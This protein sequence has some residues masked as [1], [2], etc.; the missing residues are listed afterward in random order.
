MYWPASGFWLSK[1]HGHSP[2]L[3]VHCLLPAKTLLSKQTTDSKQKPEKT[4]KSTCAH[5][6]RQTE[7]WQRN[8]SRK[9]R[10]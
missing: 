7:H 2:Q 5:L 6:D 1:D 10:R 8:I 4:R 3:K 9:S